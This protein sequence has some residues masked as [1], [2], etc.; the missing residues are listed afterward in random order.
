[1]NKLELLLER[2]R[3]VKDI[4]DESFA[5][6]NSI[7]RWKQTD[8]FSAIA[9][10]VNLFPYS[11]IILTGMGSSFYALYPL[12]CRLIQHNIPVF[13]IE[14]AEL[15]NYS[16][17]LISDDCLTIMVSQS[18]ESIEIQKLLNNR[19]RRGLTI[20]ITNTQASTL[21]TFADCSFLTHA[22]IEES[23]SC[24]TYLSALAAITIL[25]DI[26]LEDDLVNTVNALQ[27]AAQKI[28]KYLSNIED[29]VNQ[30]VDLLSET[31]YLMITGRGPSIS[32]A[33]TSSL[34]IKEAAHFFAE[35]MSSAAFRHGPYEIILSDLF[36]ITFSGN[37]NVRG[38]NKRLVDDV[39]SDGGKAVLVKQGKACDPFV[40][41]EVPDSILPIVEMLPAQMLSIALSILHGHEPGEFGLISKVTLAE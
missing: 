6:S 28:E 23:V 8:Q 36:L 11:K 21:H 29:H 5:I 2:N 39:N 26:L 30:L 15:L 27:C 33:Y 32:S 22:G 13:H 16:S 4:K 41:P 31:K 19:K 35:G 17:E 9:E 34:I 12:Y 7:D 37:K 24:K 3:Y 25:G 10:K 20:A 14:A 1:M 40:I 18:G 38:L